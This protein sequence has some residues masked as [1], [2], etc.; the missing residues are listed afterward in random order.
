MKKSVLFLIN[1][2]GIEK[3]GS[4]SISVDQI[5]P[6]LARTKETSFFQ[7]AITN[8]LEYRSAYQ[9]FFLGDT[10][11][12]EIDY[13]KNNVINDNIVNNQVYQSFLKSIETS[14]KIH[15]FLEPTSEKV[16]DVVNSLV[17]KLP[18][19]DEKAVYLHLM[20]SQP[21]V[22]EYKKLISMVNYIKYHIN[23]HITVGFIVG[24]DYFSEELNK[25]EMDIAKKLF[26]YCSAERWT[27]T[28][29]KLVSLEEA[30]IRPNIVP[31][32]CATNACNIEDNDTI[33]FFNT[34]KNNYDKFLNAILKNAPEVYKKEDYN[35]PL[36]SIIKLDS[37]YS[38]PCFTDNIV[39]TNSLSGYLEKADKKALIITDEKNI[40]LV[41]LL[42]NGMNA[43][44]N[45]R[46]QFMKF[47]IDYFKDPNA[48][49]G[50][51]DNS[52]YDLIIFD[53]HMDTTSTVNHMKE[54]LERIDV[55]IGNIANTCVNK[56]SL[57]ITSLYGIK[58]TMPLAE[59]N[60]EM[61]DINYEMQIPIFFFDYTYPRGK[62]ALFPGETN[63]ILNT[64]LRCIW[65]NPELYSLI[66]EKGIINNLIKTFK[67]N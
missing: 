57:F 48:V 34:R 61:V 44:N 38:I 21:T 31:G 22:N 18:L 39:Y 13:L 63:D 27:D 24:K 9:Q 45:P 4:Y 12:M 53:Y 7:T 52:E 64:A 23:T 67:G 19:S 33:L 35:L 3:P 26:F 14:K 60:T 50:I 5:M 47:N 62:Y 1:G 11:K 42:A 46:I 28:D 49:T 36:Y 2:L 17:E 15:V 37:S 54:E 58:K 29:K 40:P 16:V 55:I 66:K 56:H 25:E 10:Y 43:V 59:Y 30:N 8:S 20:L 32:F 65:D 6:N 41:N 51:I